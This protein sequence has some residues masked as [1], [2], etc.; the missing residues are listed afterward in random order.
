MGFNCTFMELKLHIPYKSLANALVL[1]VPLWNWNINVENCSLTASLSFNC[2]FME[3]K[4][5]CLR[6]RTCFIITVLIVPLWNW[7]RTSRAYVPTDTAVLIVPL[8]NWNSVRNNNAV[9]AEGFNCTFM[10]LKYGN[11]CRCESKAARVLIV[12]LWNWN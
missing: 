1:I 4:Y 12:P 11:G 10:E 6:I 7:N 5:I 3:L 9:A 2:T 8:W